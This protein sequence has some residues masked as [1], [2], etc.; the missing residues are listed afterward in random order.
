MKAL[1]TLAILLSI[2]IPSFARLGETEAQSTARYGASLHSYPCPSSKC[3]E[4]DF[5]KDGIFISECFIEDKCCEM[6]VRKAP[7]ADFA[8]ANPKGDTS[9]PPLNLEEAK[10]LLNQNAEGHQWV[11]AQTFPTDCTAAWDR[12]DGG[13]AGIIGGSLLLQNPDWKLFIGENGKAM[14]A[15]RE[16]AAQKSLNGM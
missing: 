2:T 5:W 1:L 4:L 9:V 11:T 15:A 3:K 14:R 10:V 6:S 13:T 12:D 7:S 16:R 8:Y